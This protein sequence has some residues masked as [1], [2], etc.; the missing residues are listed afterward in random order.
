MS[1]LVFNKVVTSLEELQTIM[2]EPSQLVQQKTI[3][4]IDIHCKD[5]ISKSPFIVL[6]TANDDGSCDASPRGDEAG[7]VKILDSKTIVI[8]ERPGNKKVDSMRN[9]VGNPNIGL[10]FLI[11]GLGET[12]RVNG[13]AQ[14]IQDEDILHSMAVRGKSPLIAIAITVEEAYIHCAKA[15][16]RSGIWEQ[17]SWIDKGELPSAAKMII[18]HAK[19]KDTTPEILAEGLEKAYREN[20]Y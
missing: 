7:F 6:S 9:I 8:P 15:F 5:F 18:S 12:L 19:I 13:K 1:N 3:D 11:P 17:E 14:L 4:H 2:G 10:L 16:K 20:L